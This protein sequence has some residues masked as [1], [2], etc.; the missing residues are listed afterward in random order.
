MNTGA[1]STS[2][3]NT[4]SIALPIAGIATVAISMA[5]QFA[6]IDHGSSGQVTIDSNMTG[7]GWGIGLGIIITFVGLVLYR[8]MN[9]SDRAYVW[10]FGFAWVGFLLANIA[11]MF[12]L[13]QV[14]LTKI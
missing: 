7:I 2:K 8:F 11:I 13:Y 1:A 4:L 6:V 14:Q 10:L 9:M 12:S 5:T 3:Y